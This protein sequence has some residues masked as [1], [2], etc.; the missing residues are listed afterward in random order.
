MAS[1]IAHRGPDDA[2]VWRDAAAGIGFAHRRLSIVDLSP[3]GHQP[4]YAGLPLVGELHTV[5]CF[6]S[7]PFDSH[8][9]SLIA[10]YASFQVYS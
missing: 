8:P 4:R 2:G 1:S 6:V 5:A 7:D 9:M 10:P 3:L